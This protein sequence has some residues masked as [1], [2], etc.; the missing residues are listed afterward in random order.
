MGARDG[1]VAGWIL[2]VIALF[3]LASDGNFGMVTVLVPISF[4]LACVMIGPSH[5]RVHI[6]KIAKRGRLELKQ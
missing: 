1:N 6:Q 4:L 5:E 2:T 3:L